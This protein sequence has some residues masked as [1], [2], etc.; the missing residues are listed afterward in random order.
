MR[1]DI[2]RL[3]IERNCAASRGDRAIGSRVPM[4]YLSR[5]TLGLGVRR[6][7]HRGRLRSPRMIGETP[8]CARARRLLKG[9]RKL[10]WPASASTARN[11]PHRATTGS[12][13]R[14]E[15]VGGARAERGKLLSIFNGVVPCAEAIQTFVHGAI[16]SNFETRRLSLD[17]NHIDR[18]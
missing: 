10:P 1:R 13:K 9:G 3:L 7:G 8:A 5:C 17:R 14:P 16:G 6:E 15:N 11:G 12:A 18:R 4:A 2:V